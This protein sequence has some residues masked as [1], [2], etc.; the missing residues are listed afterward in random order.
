MDQ[1]PGSFKNVEFLGIS[2]KLNDIHV[3]ILSHKILK[4]MKVTLVGMS[5]QNACGFLHKM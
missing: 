2:Q 4:R 3:N 5:V 1:N